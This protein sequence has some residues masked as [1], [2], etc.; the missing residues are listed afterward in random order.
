MTLRAAL[1]TR[2]PAHLV[3]STVSLVGEIPVT[4]NAKVDR[5]ALLAVH[6][7]P[8]AAVAEPGDGD[9]LATLGA[10]FADVLGVEVCGPD[11]SFFD[12]GGHSVLA[13][14]LVKRLRAEHDVE[15]GVTA[16]FDAPTPRA[17]AAV[18][19][20]EP[21]GRLD[22]LRAS[23]ADVL[24]LADCGPD[25]SFFDLGGHSVL[26]VRLV[27]RLRAEH[28][29]ELG[30]T[31]L[32]DAPTPRSMADAL[33]R[34]RPQAVRRRLL[35]THPFDDEART[36]LVLVNAEEQRSLWPADLA[37]PSG[38]TVE[39]GPGPR[40]ACAAHVERTWND[41]TPATLRAAR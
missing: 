31:A 18:L 32:F 25:E 17:M 2:L 19:T 15:L 26:A 1:A 34:A 30:V 14:R 41:I 22:G 3:P 40:P 35:V 28:D 7:A 5:A 13:V 16:L 20:G 38:W 36:Y 8:A 10:A 9:L 27:K 39:H 11:E 4:T 37:V 23:F 24:G 21:N 29:V 33:D 6:S 12:L